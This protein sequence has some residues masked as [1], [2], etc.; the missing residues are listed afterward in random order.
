LD[1][2]LRRIPKVELHNHVTGAVRLQTVVDLAKKNDIPMPIGNPEALYE[3]KEL[4]GFLTSHA[5]VC[6]TLRDQDDFAR[7]AYETLED[8]HV[9]GN[10]RYM[11]IF[12]NPT[13]HMKAGIPYP[14]VVDGLVEGIHRA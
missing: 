14:T 3:Y 2:F 11:E 7:V 6:G 1:E 8:G 13:I 5:F 9:H 10:V 12:F 4:I